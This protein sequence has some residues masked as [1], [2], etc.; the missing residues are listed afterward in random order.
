MTT[1]T[2]TILETVETTATCGS[3]KGGT[4]AVGKTAEGMEE[5]VGAGL[6]KAQFKKA[7]PA[8]PA[9]VVGIAAFVKGKIRITADGKVALAVVGDKK[10][11]ALAGEGKSLLAVYELIAAVPPPPGVAPSS[12]QLTRCQPCTEQTELN[13]NRRVLGVTVTTDLDQITALLLM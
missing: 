5:G 3:S 10:R 8:T 6:A 7:R 11:V 4:Q 9:E 13:G 2:T 12:R 1:T